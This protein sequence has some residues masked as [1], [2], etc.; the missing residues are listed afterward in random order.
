MAT[1]R[2]GK[3]YPIRDPIHSPREHDVGHIDILDMRDRL[4]KEDDA[5]F[6]EVEVA[7][8]GFQTRPD[9]TVTITTTDG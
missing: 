6:E 1:I 3:E 8:R 7:L 9:A 4:A 2:R 5:L